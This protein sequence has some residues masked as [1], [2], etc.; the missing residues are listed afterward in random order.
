MTYE[1]ATLHYFIQK[2]SDYE[3]GIIRIVIHHTKTYRFQNNKELYNA[4]N[5][6]L[7]DPYVSLNKYGHIS[8][9]DVSKITDMQWLFSCCNN[10][11]DDITL[12]DTGNVKN[13]KCMF[14]DANRFNQNISKW[15]TKNVICFKEMFK[16]CFIKKEYKPNLITNTV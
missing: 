14:F 4:V 11:N 10:F 2:V 7:E 16:F 5:I 6:W 1:I 15:D 3:E 8:L 9:W 13:M 12:C